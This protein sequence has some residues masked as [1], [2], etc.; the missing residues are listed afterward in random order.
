M[1]GS[2][3]LRTKLKAVS[4]PLKS[5]DWSGIAGIKS[6]LGSLEGCK[7]GRVSRNCSQGSA[8]SG[9]LP[10][11]SHG[12]MVRDLGVDSQ[13][14]MTK[15][16]GRCEAGTFQHETE[17]RNESDRPTCFGRR[18]VVYASFVWRLLR[19]RRESCEGP[20]A[21][22][23]GDGKTPEPVLLELTVIEHGKTRLRSRRGRSDALSL[24]RSRCLFEKTND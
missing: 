23:A 19:L 20:P 17:V 10:P 15:P 22:D 7:P 5:P 11:S 3:P 16:S 13:K 21:I 8:C 12:V 9:R 2:E 24:V 18:R 6:Y 14:R 1:S 4:Q